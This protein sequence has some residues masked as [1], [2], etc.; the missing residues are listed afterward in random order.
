MFWEG[1]AGEKPAAGEREEKGFGCSFLISSSIETASTYKR[2]ISLYNVLNNLL[3]WVLM[4][5]K[6][7]SHSPIEMSLTNLRIKG[8]ELS[9]GKLLHLELNFLIESFIAFIVSFSQ[10]SLE[11]KSSLVLAKRRAAHTSFQECEINSFTTHP[12]TLSLT[13]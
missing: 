6:H 10:L 13:L 2:V 7:V 9:N 8:K 11:R 12:L 4:I 1:E 3:G 5:T